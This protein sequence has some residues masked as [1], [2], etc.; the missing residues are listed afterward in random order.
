MKQLYEVVDASINTSN[1][2]SEQKSDSERIYDISK[3]DFER[4]RQE[5]A[6]SKGS[7][8]VMEKGSLTLEGKTSH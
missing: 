2:I 8:W 3:I 5:F 6:K 4:L 7:S 1:K